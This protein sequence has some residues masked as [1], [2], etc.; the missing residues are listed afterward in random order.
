[1]S[2]TSFGKRARDEAKKAKARAKRER[3][4]AAAEPVEDGVEAP[5][6]PD[7]GL[8]TDD[9]LQMIEDVHRRHAAGEMSDD[10][11]Q[12]AKADLLGRLSVD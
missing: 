7:D 4:Q 3:R 11:F 8:S 1:M 2:R 10:D 12:E 5:A 6:E 9:L